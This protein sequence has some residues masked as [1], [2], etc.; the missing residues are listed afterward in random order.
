MFGASTLDGLDSLGQIGLG[1]HGVVDTVEV[2]EDVDRPCMVV[3]LL[4]VALCGLGLRQWV[5]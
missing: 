1:T 2:L 4:V 3:R 5:T